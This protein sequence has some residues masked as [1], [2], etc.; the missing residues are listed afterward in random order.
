MEAGDSVTGCTVHY[1]NDELDGGEIIIQREVPINP[2]D[3]IKT[4]TR[5]IQLKEY[6]ILPAALEIVKE[7]LGINFC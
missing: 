2:E 1:V 6:S 5:R 7:R 4:L 3:T